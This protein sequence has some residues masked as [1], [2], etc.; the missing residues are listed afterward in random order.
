MYN[1]YLKN[2]MFLNKLLFNYVQ[3]Y[4]FCTKFLSKFQ[5]FMVITNAHTICIISFKFDCINFEKVLRNE[6]FYITIALLNGFYE[7]GKI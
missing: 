1:Y 4:N 7:N 3:N 5:N 2:V 6:V